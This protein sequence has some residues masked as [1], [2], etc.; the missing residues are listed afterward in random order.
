MERLSRPSRERRYVRLRQRIDR[1]R[2]AGQL[3]ATARDWLH[4]DPERTLPGAGRR[5]V[6]GLR[7]PP[8]RQSC[9]STLLRCD[10]RRWTA[11]GGVPVSNS[12]D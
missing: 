1:D 3:I 4:H 12:G 10:S 11:A 5:Q 6:C 7:Q 2:T 8:C 9:S